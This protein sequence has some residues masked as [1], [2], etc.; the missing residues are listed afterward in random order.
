MEL[1]H[2]ATLGEAI[3]GS[4]P[5]AP[6]LSALSHGCILFVKVCEAVNYAHQ[7][8]VV[9]RDLKPANIL[10]GLG[11]RERGRRRSRWRPR[12]STSAWPASPTPTSSPSLHTQAGAVQGTLA[13][14]SPEQAR[15]NP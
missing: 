15:G 7:R 9:H 5:A 2:G 10:V 3:R 4:G 1:A 12:S 11:T 13:Y 6:A 14:M 8:G